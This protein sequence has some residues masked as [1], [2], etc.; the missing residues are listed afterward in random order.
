MDDVV[1]DFKTA[2]LALL[3]P[4]VAEAA[5]AA[6]SGRWSTD[7]WNRI[8]S[9]PHFFRHLPKMPRADELMNLARRFRD[10]LAWEVYM[11]T[12]I[13]TANDVPDCVQDKVEWQQE[14]YPDIRVRFGPFA[15]DKKKF[16]KGNDILVDDRLS[17]IDDWSAQGGTAV[18][19]TEDYDLALRELEELFASPLA[20]A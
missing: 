14:H 1:A 18:R 19:V 6:R 4:T 5:E 3:Q 20:R 9:T 11:L 8:A 12:A 2:S 7:N 10:E 16:C 13:P 17:N 15:A